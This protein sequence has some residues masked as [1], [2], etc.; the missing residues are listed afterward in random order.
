MRTGGTPVL[1]NQLHP[2]IHNS[3]KWCVGLGTS[4][5]NWRGIFEQVSKVELGAQS[6]FLLSKLLYISVLQSF[7]S[8][9][10]FLNRVGTVSAY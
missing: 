8:G 6:G 2:L 5:S 3:E 1:P 7:E 4:V 9:F 10:P